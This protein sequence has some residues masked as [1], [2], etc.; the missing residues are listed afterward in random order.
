MLCERNGRSERHVIIIAYVNIKGL[1][2]KS[3][4]AWTSP[5]YD[6]NNSVERCRHSRSSFAFYCYKI[7]T[8]ISKLME[9]VS[10]FSNRRTDRRTDNLRTTS[11]MFP[12]SDLDLWP[13][14]LKIFLAVVPDMDNLS[15]KSDGCSLWFAVFKLTVLDRQTDRQTEEVYSAMRPPGGGP[16]NNKFVSWNYSTLLYCT[17]SLFMDITIGPLL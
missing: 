17:N 11:F 2:R 12:P 13:F 7:V 16:L 8:V 1:S 3:H 14:A 6:V 15:S 4:I 10:S 9:F 5:L